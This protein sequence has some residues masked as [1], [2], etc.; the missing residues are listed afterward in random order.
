MAEFE[1]QYARCERRLAALLRY[2]DE[3]VPYRD[4]AD[5]SLEELAAYGVTAEDRELLQPFFEHFPLEGLTSAQIANLESHMPNYLKAQ[6]NESPDCGDAI[7]AFFQ[8][9]YHLKDWIKN[10]LTSPQR[11]SVESFVSHSKNL[12][13]CADICNGSKHL[14]LIRSRTGCVPKLGGHEVSFRPVH[15]PNRRR[16]Y[17]TYK[18]DSGDQSLDVFDVAENCM[19]EW[20]HFL[21]L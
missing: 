2:R 5:M 8:D 18:I 17:V 11:T 20:K 6:S 16:R 21:G 19:A 10:D 12:S 9:C 13:L 15:G 1:K 14:T 7:Y 4:P 3:G